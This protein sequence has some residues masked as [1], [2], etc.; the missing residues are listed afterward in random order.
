MVLT[1]RGKVE[2]GPFLFGTGD[3]PGLP[4][5]SFQARHPATGRTVLFEGLS[6][7][8]ILSSKLAMQ[9][10][11]DTLVL[12]SRDG[13]AVPVPLVLVKQWKPILADRADGRPLAEWALEA[14]ARVG[15]L[16]LAWPNVDNPGLATDPRAPAFWAGAVDAVEV[17]VWRQTWGRALRVPPGAPDAARL[18][19]DAILYRCMT[20]HR[21]RG[22]GGE[23]APELTRVVGSAGP[24]AFATRMRA[25][26][27]KVRP[28]PAP[29][30]GEGE[31]LG[32][33]ARF[34]AAVEVATPAK[35]EAGAKAG[36]PEEDLEPEEPGPGRPPP[37][38]R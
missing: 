19:A 35:A 26:L 1:V 29:G 27:A 32:G 28:V 21:L 5:R 34:L 9:E 25:H 38:R 3:L 17:V 24:D 8:E 16:L 15:P 12:R 22:V 6:L 7:A 2:H 4:R 10:R 13:S 33:I 30:E 20:C 14:G 36:E 23:R 11:A 37:R 18:G 31:A